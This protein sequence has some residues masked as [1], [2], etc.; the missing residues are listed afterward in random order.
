MGLLRSR[1]KK[2]DSKS[3]RNVFQYRVKQNAN[4]QYELYRQSRSKPLFTPSNLKD[5]REQETNASKISL[6]I[7]FLFLQQYSA[8]KIEL[9][10]RVHIILSFLLSQKAFNSAF[11]IDMIR[12]CRRRLGNR[13]LSALYNNWRLKR[14]YFSLLL[15]NIL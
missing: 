2:N 6:S 8:D 5:Y 11:P 4:F 3:E 15:R 10:K 1:L 9:K 7:V 14:Y 12:N 13:Q